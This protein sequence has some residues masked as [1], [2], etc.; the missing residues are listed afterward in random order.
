MTPRTSASSLD[1][2]APLSEPVKQDAKDGP[3]GDS[4]EESIDVDDNEGFLSTPAGEL[5]LFRALIEHRPVGVDKHWEMLQVAMS[6]SKH[7]QWSGGATGAESAQL[8]TTMTDEQHDKTSVQDSTHKRKRQRNNLDDV[9]S[10]ALWAKYRDLYDGDTL[11]S[12]WEG[13]ASRQT[14][15][16]LDKMDTLGLL[17]PTPDSASDAAP[18]DPTEL[19][20]NF[21]FPKREFT[22]TP[23]F[24]RIDKDERVWDKG[25]VGDF[26][27][28]IADR[29]KR[30]D[31][32]D[33]D[34][35]ESLP[36]TEF[37]VQVPSDWEGFDLDDED[38]K[39]RAKPSRRAAG[40]GDVDQSSD[41]DGEGQ[42]ENDKGGRRRKH[43]GRDSPKG[44]GARSRAATKAVND[45]VKERD[46]QR[47]QV[48]SSKAGSTTATPPSKRRQRTEA[49]LDDATA[50]TD[51]IS[52]S[53]L[54]EL[55]DATDEEDDGNNKDDDDSA[56]AETD[57]D[58]GD[59][60]DIDRSDSALSDHD[61][62]ADTTTSRSVKR[63]RSESAPTSEANS[64]YSGP[65]GTA[66]RRSTGRIRRPPV[67]EGFEV[68]TPASTRASR[69]KR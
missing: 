48:T 5:A 28:R 9:D 66:A 10:A 7:A 22:L 63:R 40:K 2:A 23:H 4:A 64:I 47:K 45:R 52:G 41:R 13:E 56:A 65:E 54:S 31:G 60:D 53:E 17:P 32:Q 68:E 27:Q 15:L 38:D 30:V 21:R 44:R 26:S 6:L 18:L 69:R 46:R 43:V 14:Y 51:E 61:S 58:D 33:P 36:V 8:E 16:Q 1:W 3:A 35:P 19:C 39:P 34:S 55:E 42:D 25:L 37:D 67:K 59:E 49:E 50:G 24:K 62:H 29:A 11:W 57:L 20:I 12:T